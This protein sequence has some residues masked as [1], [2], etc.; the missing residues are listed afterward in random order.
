MTAVGT[1]KETGD[2]WC[3]SQ[4]RETTIVSVDGQ[5]TGARPRACVAGPMPMQRR[6]DNLN[7]G[8]GAPDALPPPEQAFRLT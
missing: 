1:S 4:P 3:M 7:L 6:R 8:G 5:T 2:Q